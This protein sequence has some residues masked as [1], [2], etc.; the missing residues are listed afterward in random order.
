V[1]PQVRFELTTCG[2]TVRR[3]NQ[4]SYWGIDFFFTYVLVFYFKVAPQVRF[5]LTTC[6]LTVRRSNQLSYW[7]IGITLKLLKIGSPGKIRTYDLRINSP[8]L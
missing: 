6:G 2:L 1:A 3:S 5:E 7:G 4:L 8:S